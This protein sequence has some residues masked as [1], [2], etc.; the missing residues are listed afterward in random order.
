MIRLRSTLLA[1]LAFFLVFVT[2]SYLIN[3]VWFADA[4]AKIEFFRSEDDPIGSFIGLAIVTGVWSLLIAFCYLLV[5][6]KLPDWPPI[7]KGAAYGCVVFLFFIWPQEVLY[8]QFVEFNWGIIASALLHMALSFVVGGAV[9]G[10]V[11][12]LCRS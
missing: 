10:V 9:I 11:Q 8:F 4:H 3:V 1:G 5:E 6:T 2:L 7:L 12:S